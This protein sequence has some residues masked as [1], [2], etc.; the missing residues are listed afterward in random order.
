[1]QDVIEKIKAL[2]V[3]LEENRRQ[4]E[5][6][7]IS[8]NDTVETL[9]KSRSQDERDQ[10]ALLRDRI[11]GQMNGKM[12]RPSD[13]TEALF[14]GPGH[15]EEVEAMLEVLYNEGVVNKRDRGW[16]ELVD[17]PDPSQAVPA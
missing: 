1:M 15:V 5:A 10:E 16:W 4:V 3:E 12:Q 8:L 13:L 7:I 2:I 6:A 9:S 11:I 14:D 17:T